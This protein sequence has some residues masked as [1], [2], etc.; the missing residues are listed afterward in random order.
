MIKNYFRVAFRNLYKNKIYSFI[1]IIGLSIGITCSLLILLW[2]NDET[3]YDRFIPKAGHLYQVW[4]NAKYD[5]KINSWRSVSLPLYEELKNANT[6]IKNST[7]SD[8]GGDHLLSVGD[9]KLTKQ[10]FYVGGEF[11][12]MFQFPVLNGDPKTILN[13]A[14]SIVITEKTAKEF[15]GDEDPVNKIIRVDDKTDLKVSGVI[16]DV[17]ENSS[18][19]FDFLLPYK[20]WRSV[21]PWV[22]RN[23]TN[24]G[25]YSF[26]VYVELSDGIHKHAVENSIK[27][28]LIDHGEK[29]IKPELFLY[30]M[31]RWHL[32]S[33][34]DNG[35]E[36]AG[37]SDFVKMFSVTALFILMIAC[38]NFMNLSTARSAGRA[39]EVGIRKAMGSRRFDLIFQ[40]IS[41]SLLITFFAFAIAIV[42]TQATLPLYNELVEKELSIHYSSPYFW[43]ASFLMIILTGV[44]SGSYPAFYLS[45]FRPV[46]VLKGK[47]L[48][49]KRAGIP[50]KALVI[51]QFG[52]SILLI[53]GTIVIFKQIKLAKGRELGYDQDNL[54]MVRRNE[55]LDKNYEVLKNELLQ[56][57][58]VDGVTQSNSQI[59][60]INS[61]NFLGWPG[62]PDDQRVIFV[63]I[64]ANYDYAKTMGIKVLKGRDFSK[65]FK[66]DSSAIMINKAAMDL[67]KLP[68]PIG[69]QLD[70]WGKKRTLIGVIDNVIMG[71]PY[72]EI[73]P[74]FVILDDWGG[75][76]TIR[77]HKTHDLNGSLNRID[78]IFRKYNAAYPFEYKFADQEF[79][80]KFKSINLTSHL[81][82]IFATLAIVITGLGL[83]GLAAYTIEQRTKEIGIRKVMGASV[84]SIIFLMSKDFAWLVI[85][86]FIISA[87][88]SWWVLKI[89]LKK[90]PIHTGTPLWIFVATGVFALCFALLIVITQSMKAAQT[91]PA[92]TLRDE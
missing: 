89:Y 87:P 27:N 45:S 13:D 59:T 92:I 26:Q 72:Q 25:N 56:S 39:R 53:A 71:S 24:W 82:N 76:I 1:N 8:W 43:S 79:A 18:F 36:K 12:T 35:K 66:S 19:K 55:E 10:G 41:E 11:L 50:R 42:L 80:K 91:N 21:N 20:Y 61:N 31:L 38:I 15:F 40:F 84:F 34:F 63:T 65:D 64:S 90:F 49:G 57:G 2:V 32:Y 52:F 74:L 69:T 60:D 54:I 17:P 5:G 23:E 73:R 4:I 86:A 3:T 88:V 7:V 83:L 22:V 6:Y 62:K 51:I 29:E 78:D 16:K 33:N 58:V 46:K 28:I 14:S 81:V 30:P 37:M 9:K 48:E 70:L 44:I 68:D 77:I 47:I 67:M 85:M 75:Y